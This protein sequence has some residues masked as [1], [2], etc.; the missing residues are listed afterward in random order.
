[1][2]QLTK[3]TEFYKSWSGYN[4]ELCWAATWLYR[5]SEINHFST[6]AKKYYKSLKCN[7]ASGPISWDD[8]SL[9]VQLHMAKLFPENEEYAEK[10][11]EEADKLLLDHHKSRIEFNI[12]F[13]HFYKKN[14]N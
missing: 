13:L 3:V 11:R 6:I 10:I 4:D 2:F 9:L 1:M 7:Y 14:Y 5:A 8:K 12:N